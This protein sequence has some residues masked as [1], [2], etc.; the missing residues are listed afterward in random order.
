MKIYSI[1]LVLPLFISLNQIKASTDDENI[2]KIIQFIKNVDAKKLSGY[3]NTTIDLELGDIDGSYSKTQ[4]EIIIND[5]FKTNPAKSFTLNHQGSSDDGSK[6]IIGT[7]KCSATEYRVYILLKKQSDE[8][9]IYQL[10][11]EED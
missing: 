5:F 2:E 11:F 4:A 8:L 7:Y 10:Q 9:L 1:L 3:F 6:Y